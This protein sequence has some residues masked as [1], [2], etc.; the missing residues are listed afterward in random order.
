MKIAMLVD[1]MGSG[2]KTAEDE[3]DEIEEK[4]SDVLG[5][6]N[7]FI[8]QVRPDELSN[9]PVDVYV[10]DFGGLL[11]GVSS[12]INSYHRELAKQVEDHPNT[13]FVIWSSFTGNEYNQ[14]LCEEAQERVGKQHNLIVCNGMDDELVERLKHLK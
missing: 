5:K 1:F 2:E 3:Y 7:T 8:R 10:F 13:L 4:F 12:L 11:P 9:N 6:E 14:F